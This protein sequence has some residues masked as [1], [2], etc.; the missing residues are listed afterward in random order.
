MNNIIS[1]LKAAL[2]GKNIKIQFVHETV[3]TSPA[4]YNHETGIITI[5]INGAFKNSNGYDNIAAQTVLHELIHAITVE[6]IKH[7]PELRSEL[8]DLFN[9]V[10][11]SARIAYEGVHPVYGLKD[12]YE[13]IAELSNENFVKSLQGIHTGSNRK[14]LISMVIDFMRKVI[15]KILTSINKKWQGTAYADAMEL[16]MKAA[17]PQDF[18]IKL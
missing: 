12:V 15:N 7:S 1:I 10:K 13:F 16:L 2:K 3:E 11:Q 4:Y 9:K 14:E 17:F 5:N 6:T 8:E 18:N